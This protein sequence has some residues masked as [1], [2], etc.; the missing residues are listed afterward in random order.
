MK[1]IG[2]LIAGMLLF[3][4]QALAQAPNPAASA[5]A[6]EHVHH[7][8][9]DVLRVDPIYDQD[10]SSAPQQEC[11]E[12][13]VFVAADDGKRSVV[14]VFGAIIGGLIGNRVGKGDG[15]KAAT[16]A[17]AV[18][19]GVVGN[20]LAVESDNRNEPKYT[21]QRHCRSI[22]ATASER[23]VVA[24][25]VEYRYRGEVYASRLAYDPGDRMRVQVSVMP[26]E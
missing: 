23:H 10:V 19:G 9:A 11:Y 3:T 17:G 12:E 2:I 7:G 6:D 21:T 4:G 26:A 25:E 14:T 13:Q 18:A 24:Y 15:R 22:G 1:I 5:S 8:W 20:N 16:A